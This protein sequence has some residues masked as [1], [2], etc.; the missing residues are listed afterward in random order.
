MLFRSLPATF[1]TGRFYPVLALVVALGLVFAVAF[2]VNIF[3]TDE[4]IVHELMESFKH[5]DLLGS[6]DRNTQFQNN[7]SRRLD[8]IE[9]NNHEAKDHLLMDVTVVEARYEA[10]MKLLGV[11]EAPVDE[12]QQV[13]DEGK[14]E[15]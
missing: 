9:A 6:F 4:N 8:R 7:T 1:A 15:L 2:Q 11:V 10:L 12:G 3:L 5:H 14:E 13:Q